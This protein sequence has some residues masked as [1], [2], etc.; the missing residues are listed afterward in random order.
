MDILGHFETF[1]DIFR[2]FGKLLD[3]FGAFRLLSYLF[4]TIFSHNKLIDKNAFRT[5][6]PTTDRPTDKQTLL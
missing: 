5:E 1:R 4:P 6:G 3:E 2:D